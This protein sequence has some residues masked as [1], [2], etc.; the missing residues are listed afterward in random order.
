M[1]IIQQSGFDFC[2]DTEA[3][4][5]CR[6]FCCRGKSGH[7]WI[8][9][10]DVRSIGAFLNVN[11]VDFIR[12]FTDRS[13]NRLSLKERYID[14]NYA[15]TFF[16]T[17]RKKCSIYKVRPDQCRRFPFWDYFREHREELAREC[18]GIRKC[19]PTE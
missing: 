15:C 5:A 8:G 9:E 19:A 18:P 1:P 4:A 16:D 11:S 2:F 14:G 17:S 13:N 7:V 10:Q 12:R 6:G 3:C